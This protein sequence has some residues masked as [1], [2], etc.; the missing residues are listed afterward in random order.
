MKI[1]QKFILFLSLLLAPNASYSYP[2][3]YYKTR[4]Q[5]DNVQLFLYGTV[6][7][8]TASIGLG[9]AWHN[10]LSPYQPWILITQEGIA[11]KTDTMTWDQLQ[12]IHEIMDQN[13][14]TAALKFVYTKKDGVVSSIFLNLFYLPCS[15]E[16]FLTFI[17]EYK[18]NKTS[19]NVNEKSLIFPTN[20]FTKEQ[21][22]Q[23]KKTGFYK[24]ENSIIICYGKFGWLALTA[25]SIPV[26]GS[27]LSLLYILEKYKL[28]LEEQYFNL[29]QG[30]ADQPTQN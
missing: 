17:N 9:I 13:R 3:A 22:A 29:C 4:D 15:K 8:L 21:L 5:S 30:S 11:T 16:Q 25:M 7:A 1:K 20:S 18:K 2:P 19:Q 6:L 14:K 24:D 23:I 28:K 12:T 10:R 26:Y 27:L